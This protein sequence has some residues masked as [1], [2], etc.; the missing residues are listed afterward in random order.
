VSTTDAKHNRE[1]RVKARFGRR[2]GGA[3]LVL[4]GEPQ[5]QRA[6]ARGAQGEREL[7][8]VLD[9][10]PGVRVLH[11]RRVPGTRANIDH[12]VVASAGVFV[13]DA[14]VY[15]GTIRIRDVGGLF[16]KE[17]RLYVGS[18]DCSH[19]ADALA[20]QVQAV[21]T[22]LRSLEPVVPITPVLCFVRGEWP[23]LRPPTEFRGVRLE[24]TRSI[25]RLV[26]TPGTLPSS[27]IADLASAI[28][29][30]MAS[31]DSEA[32]RYVDEARSFRR[33]SVTSWRW[34]A[35]RA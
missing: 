27:A 8:K 4:S 16:R 31:H 2:L 1:L 7:G 32:F 35:G 3:L 11:D 23:L 22:A 30:R 9:S 28:L 24:G 17:E 26:A 19:L 13:I 18:R 20:H 29:T 34:L 14:K 25:Q 33:I 15:K 6:W 12:I 10:I 5:S 21:R